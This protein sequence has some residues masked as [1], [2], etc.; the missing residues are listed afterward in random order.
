MLNWQLNIVGA[1]K[2]S[3]ATHPISR[4]KRAGKSLKVHAKAWLSTGFTNLEGTFLLAL[5]GWLAL[6]MWLQNVQKIYCAFF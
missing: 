2:K 1:I 3:L 4:Q 6:K 5:A